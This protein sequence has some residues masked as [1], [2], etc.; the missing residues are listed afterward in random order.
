MKSIPR[1]ELTGYSLPQLVRAG[2]IAG[3]W[4]VFYVVLLAAAGPAADPGRDHTFA[5]ASGAD[6][7]NTLAGSVVLDSADRGLASRGAR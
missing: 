7:V 3:V 5:S 1:S 4:V 6:Q 2:V